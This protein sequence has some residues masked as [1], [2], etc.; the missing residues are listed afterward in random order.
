[1][2]NLQIFQPFVVA[3]ILGSLLG[4]ERAFSVKMEDN[5]EDV[6]A[7]IRTFSL[8]ALLGCIAAYLDR[9]LVSGILLLSFAAIIV[10][11]AVSY[12]ISFFKHNDRGITTEVSIFI[13]FS[14]GVMVQMGNV[15]VA[16]FITILVAIILYLK[17]TTD[18]LSR[19]IEAEDIRAV[20]K[21]AIVTFVILPIFDPK[22]HLTLGDIGPVHRLFEINAPGLLAIEL[23]NPHTVWLMVVLIS[24]ISFTGYFAI[25]LLGSRKGVGLTGLMGGIVSSTATTME[26]SRR[27][28]LNTNQYL[29]FSLA[30]VLACT[31]MFPRILVE[32]LVVNASLVPSLSITMGFMAVT[33]IVIS[34]VLWRKTGR[35]STEEVPLKNPF[36]I[37]PALQFGILYAIIVFLARFMSEVAGDS[38]VYIVSVLSGLTDVDAIT[39]SMSQLSKQDPTKL[40]QATIAITLAA[41]SNTIM[42]AIIAA[43]IGTKELRKVIFIG[44]T[45]IIAAGVAGLVINSAL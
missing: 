5:R 1:M 44:F 2:L 36:S 43:S 30:I 3:L 12:Y 23:V 7:G 4:F 25:K 34:L 38:G 19:R 24:A 20:L 32:V 14:I 31:I 9:E 28:R 39:L 27:S 10:I 29:P 21:F 13:C 45:I 6:F 22:F 17:K 8:I 33:G 42:K 26:F 18:D 40:N 41:F 16:T 15:Q 35:E 11:T 37:I